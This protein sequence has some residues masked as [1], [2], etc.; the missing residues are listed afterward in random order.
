MRIL[1]LLPLLILL[2]A[3]GEWGRKVPEEVA[4]ARKEATRRACIANQLSQNSDEEVTTLQRATGIAAPS[5]GQNVP[6]S[7]A[8]AALAFARAYNQHAQLRT[9]AYAQMD[10]AL[11]YSPTKA[12]S[13]RHASNAAK[14][15]LSAPEPGSVEANVIAN[16]EQR[17]AVVY[18][19]PRHPCNWLGQGES[20]KFGS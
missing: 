14:F 3:C 15:E 10:S 13:A 1:P 12:D 9:A 4:T 17:F 7:A 19:D 20:E 5:A 18:N 11:N 2:T 16:Y 6:Q 8:T